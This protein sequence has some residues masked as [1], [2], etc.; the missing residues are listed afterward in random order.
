MRTTVYVAAEVDRGLL[1]RLESD[2]RI[3][4]RFEPIATE[5]ELASRIGSCEVIVSRHHNRLS[6][7]V[8]EAAPRLRLVIQG[9]SGLDNI[10]L[11]AAAARGVE[12]I[13][14][15]GENANAVAE[16]VIGC[17]IA[18]T[19]TIPAYSAEMRRSRWSREDCAT[20]LELRSHRLGI[21][22]IG[23]VGSR[24][25]TLARAVG[26]AAS[27]FDPY[28]D[29]EEITR[30]GATPAA[31]LDE[32]LQQSSI[33][34]VHV[35][36]TPETRGMIAARELALLR[37]GAVVVN[38]ARGPVMVVDDVLDTLQKGQ[39]SGAALDVFDEEPPKHAWPD[40]PQLI[41]TPHI[42]GCSGDSK[43]TIGE[44]IY[45]HVDRYLRSR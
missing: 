42:A 35:P 23:R 8:F 20:R 28:V 11:E 1:R 44:R 14:V 2:E 30:R 32:L 27:A 3:E 41:L 39:L 38:A 31:T 25:A 29:R 16:Y 26:L 9:T 13:G 45:E 10:D 19:R 24:V 36:L 43:E 33:L 4:L 18:L 40:N 7:L 6:S 5:A 22:G 12:V 21:V 34:T 15:P 17:L 37:P